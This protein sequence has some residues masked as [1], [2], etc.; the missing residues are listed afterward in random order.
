M[1]TPV[2]ARCE[3]RAL[4]NMVTSAVVLS[5][6]DCAGV[7]NQVCRGYKSWASG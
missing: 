7:G 3:M 5:A 4:N 6:L 2:I 1:P